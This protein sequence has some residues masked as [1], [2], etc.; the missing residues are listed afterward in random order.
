M[1]LKREVCGREVEKE[2]GEETDGVGMGGDAERKQ[3]GGEE[4]RRDE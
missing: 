1:A 4:R 3:K 2:R